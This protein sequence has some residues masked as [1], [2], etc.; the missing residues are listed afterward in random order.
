M[1]SDGFVANFA[2]SADAFAAADAIV[3]A[4]SRADACVV[5][6]SEGAAWRLAVQAR[7]SAATVRRAIED[8]RREVMSRQGE[9]HA[10]DDDLDVMRELPARA[11]DGAL[12][13][14]SLPLAAASAFAETA[15]SL[16]SLATLVA[17][18]ASGILRVHLMGDDEAVIREAEALLLAARAVGGA[19]RVE[20]RA[21][22]LRPHLPTWA[23]R[24]N[25]DF[26]MRRIK[27][28]FDPAGILEPGRTAF[29]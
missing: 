28:A 8:A 6:R 3:R 2:R 21:E 13:R 16:E 5:G 10:L 14:V 19:A 23:T 9:T 11:T 12:V 26:L 17:D 18:A 1:T 15:A 25:G 7:G 20:R 24:P 22:Q 4:A 29:L 27:D